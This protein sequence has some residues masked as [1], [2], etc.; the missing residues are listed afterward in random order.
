MAESL[1]VVC[2]LVA[3]AITLWWGADW[4]QNNVTISINKEER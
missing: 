2:I 3:L 1:G 4:L